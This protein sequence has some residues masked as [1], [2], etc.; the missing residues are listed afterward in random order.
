MY[1]MINGAS[2]IIF[3]Y[4]SEKRIEKILLNILQ[5]H[6]PSGVDAEI[7]LMDNVS[8]DNTVKIATHYWASQNSPISLR[9]IR[10]NK[11]GLVFA[12]ETAI[13]NSKYDVLIFLDDDNLLAQGYLTNVIEI[14]Q[15]NPE[16]GIIGG[17]I[18]PQYEIAPPQ[19]FNDHQ[20]VLAVGKQ[21][22]MVGEVR[23]EKG[24]VWG[25][26]MVI[27]KKVLDEL[28]SAGFKF[29]KRYYKGKL[30]GYADDYELCLFTQLAGYKIYYSDTLSLYHLIPAG[31][32]NFNYLKNNSFKQGYSSV[33]VDSLTDIILED[34]LNKN[35]YW[36]FTK[37]ILN[38]LKN[39]TRLLF[40]RVFYFN[41]NNILNCNYYSG[42]LAHLLLSVKYY[43]A[44]YK[45]VIGIY[46]KLS[47]NLSQ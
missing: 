41:R 21:N 24:F 33:M 28:F 45:K 15:Q 42:R 3:G 19:W 10:E 39:I 16:V 22:E 12:R 27:R 14:L 23:R 1:D 35:I 34:S 40:I 36:L 46:Q 13:Q 7:I 38:C 5:L 11:E 26:G 20:Y 29:S 4:N 30:I 2:I 47:H 31:K 32:L 6:I 43:P 37:H 8:T 18:I 44:R 25:A 17:E 9:V